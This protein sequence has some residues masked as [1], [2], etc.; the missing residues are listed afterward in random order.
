MIV[1]VDHVLL[2]YGRGMMTSARSFDYRGTTGTRN[3]KDFHESFKEKK[4][5]VS[6]NLVRYERMNKMHA[7]VMYILWRNT[8]AM[9]NGDVKL[10]DLCVQTYL[11]CRTYTI[12]IHND[13]QVYVVPKF[14]NVRAVT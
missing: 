13:L 2:L 8:R 5:T 12:H 11:V 9:Q 10:L 14:R 3:I 6:D 1:I 4:P 7:R